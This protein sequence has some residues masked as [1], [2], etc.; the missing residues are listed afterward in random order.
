MTTHLKTYS[1]GK[2]HLMVLSFD[3]FANPPFG[4][5]QTLVISIVSLLK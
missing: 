1:K 3:P 2:K 5:E 4:S